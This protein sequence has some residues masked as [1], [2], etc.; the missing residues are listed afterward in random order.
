M[1]DALVDPREVEAIARAR[2]KA[3]S[4]RKRARGE[5]VRYWHGLWPEQRRA[6]VEAVRQELSA[7]PGQPSTM[8][9][10]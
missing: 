4:Q 7:R 1:A 2:Y 9:V 10:G 6:L 3:A 8:K 5:R